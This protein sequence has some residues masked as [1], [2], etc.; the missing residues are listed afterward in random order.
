ML[1]PYF[2]LALMYDLQYTLDNNKNNYYFFH[3]KIEYLLR[4]IIFALKVSLFYFGNAHIKKH[5]QMT[6][7]ED[8]SNIIFGISST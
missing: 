6:Y 7:H 2:W 5:R 4:M 8:A 3:L 1:Y